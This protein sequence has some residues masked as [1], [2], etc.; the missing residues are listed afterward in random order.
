M[1]TDHQDANE[2]R[3]IEIVEIMF[4]ISELGGRSVKSFDL[5]EEN[6]VD[7]D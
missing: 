2:H 6:V 5:L 3:I 1:D 4:L 7:F